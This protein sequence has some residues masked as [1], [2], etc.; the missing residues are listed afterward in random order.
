MTRRILGLSSFSERDELGL[1]VFCALFGAW[2]R[3]RKVGLLQ[4]F[5]KNW[6]GS[7]GVFCG[8]SVVSCVVKTVILKGVFRD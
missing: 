3:A 7:R 5:L 4:G 6:V 1:P 8:E 2:W